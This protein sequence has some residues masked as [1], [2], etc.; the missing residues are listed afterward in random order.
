MSES[1]PQSA[2]FTTDCSRSHRGAV[3]NVCT[4]SL[5]DDDVGM[6]IAPITQ[7]GLDSKR[8]PLRTSHR[9]SV[10]FKVDGEDIGY[11]YF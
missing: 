9:A 11:P 6:A 2:E 1:S 8:N 4:A 7:Q 5:S 10:F 3:Q